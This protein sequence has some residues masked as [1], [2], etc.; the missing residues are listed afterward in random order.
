MRLGIHA[1]CLIFFPAST[2]LGIIHQPLVKESYI[3]L[4]K[5]IRPMF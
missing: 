3:G 4:N 2:Q 1:N 5:E